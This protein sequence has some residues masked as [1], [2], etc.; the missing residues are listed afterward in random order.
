MSHPANEQWSD[1]LRDL[2]D[3]ETVL[4]GEREIAATSRNEAFIIQVTHELD[5]VRAEIA[6][7]YK[8]L[9]GF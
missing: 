4:L 1:K 3:L 7:L 8:Y 5:S 9:T 6:R 2:L